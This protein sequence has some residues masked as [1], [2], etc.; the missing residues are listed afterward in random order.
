VNLALSPEDE[1]RLDSVGWLQGAF[2]RGV[3]IDLGRRD[4]AVFAALDDLL[5]EVLCEDASY[6]SVP[7]L[8]RVERLRIVGLVVQPLEQQAAVR[9]EFS[10]HPG[11][12]HLRCERVVI[13]KDSVAGP[14]GVR[15]NVQRLG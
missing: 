14:T 1:K 2:L 12:I 9:V 8:L 15:V 7:D 5:V 6:I 3:Q 4:V 13:R 10:N 11:E